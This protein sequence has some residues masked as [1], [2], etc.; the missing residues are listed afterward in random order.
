MSEKGFGVL[1]AKA[2]QSNGLGTVGVGDKNELVVGIVDGENG[3]ADEGLSHMLGAQGSSGGMG[4]GVF[5][6]EKIM[7][8]L[9]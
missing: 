7:M 8:S 6:E 3:G 9:S 5:R 2:K 1:L 4:K